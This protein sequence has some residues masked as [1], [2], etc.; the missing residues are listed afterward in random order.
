M[1]GGGVC[2]CAGG[3]GEPKRRKAEKDQPIADGGEC[4]QC[5]PSAGQL[6]PL[7]HLL[8]GGTSL[9]LPPATPAELYFSKALWPDFGEAQLAEALRS[10]AGRERRF[11]G[12]RHGGSSGSGS[13]SSGGSS[14][15]RGDAWQ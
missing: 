15:A 1:L 13:G 8:T 12:R 3:R 4:C 11:G 9:L 2:R 7:W 6:W 14:K 10:Y 5:A